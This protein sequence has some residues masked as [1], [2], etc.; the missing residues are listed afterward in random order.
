MGLSAG[1][2]FSDDKD[3][4]ILDEG[5]G[6]IWQK[7]SRGLGPVDCSGEAVPENWQ[8]ALKACK[9]LSLQGR[10]WRLPSINEL[11]SI[12]DYSRIK[13]SINTTFFPKT[14]QSLYWSSTSFVADPSKAWYVDFTT[15]V[16][17]VWSGI[18]TADIY[19]V[20]CVSGP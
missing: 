2:R 19:Y 1:A 15:G 18:K 7:C 10:S 17:T 9:N 3:G 11:K 5:T 13:P 12:V 4:T 8:Q 16:V 20:R 6:L 14:V